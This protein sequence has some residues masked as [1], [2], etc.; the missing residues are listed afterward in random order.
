MIDDSGAGKLLLANGRSPAKKSG[1]L[2]TKQQ[3]EDFVERYVDQ[4][5]EHYMR[6]IPELVA[7]MLAK[8]FEANGLTLQGPPKE[9]PQDGTAFL[10]SLERAGIITEGPTESVPTDAEGPE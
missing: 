5:I 8:A 1:D 9:Q 7:T 10:A 4:H 6:Q 2:V 3:V